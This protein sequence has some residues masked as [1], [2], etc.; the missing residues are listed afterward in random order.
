MRKPR[1]IAGLSPKDWTF[2]EWPEW[3]AD[4]AVAANRSHAS[5]ITET[6][7][8]QGISDCGRLSLLIE[9]LQTTKNQHVAR[10]FP[11][12]W[13]REFS[14][15]DQGIFIPEQRIALGAQGMRMG[16]S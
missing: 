10:Q 8:L 11:A 16:V 15:G 3:V 9:Q 6:G 14:A 1:G 13:N 4:D 7:N 2:P 12:Q 5:E